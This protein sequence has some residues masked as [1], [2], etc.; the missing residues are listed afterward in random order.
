MAAFETLP[1]ETPIDDISGLKVRSITTRAALNKV[2]AE[3]IRKAIVKYLSGKP[4]RRA[5]RFDLAWLLQLHREMFGD[6]WTWAGSLRVSVTNLGVAPE[7]IEV[8]LKNLLD[9]F[10]YWVEHGIDLMQ[11]AVM[12]HH[13][14]VQV[15][16]FPNGNGRWARLLTNIWLKMNNKPPIE[17]PEATIG[18]VSVIRNEYID[19]IKAADA[20]DYDPMLSLHKRF[21]PE[22]T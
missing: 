9:D 8:Q 17:W 16:P 20:G 4:S 21:T 13:R 3:N 5:A 19:A 14:A 10:A 18:T 12:L 11:Q 2:E 1:G 15:H 6:V 22:R 7:K